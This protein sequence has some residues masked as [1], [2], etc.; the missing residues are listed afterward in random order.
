MWF[1]RCFV[2]FASVVV[3]IVVV[4]FVVVSFCFAFV[5]VVF[6]TSIDR[7][8]S[9]NNQPLLHFLILP[10]DAWYNRS[11]VYTGKHRARSGGR[12][13]TSTSRQLYQGAMYFGYVCPNRSTST[14]ELTPVEGTRESTTNK[15]EPTKQREEDREA[16]LLMRDTKH[17]G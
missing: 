16:L 14:N 1:V 7:G 13:Y 15:T 12:R 8:S 10:R 9:V 3:R 5:C 6:H 17:Q 4:A 11:N 2:S